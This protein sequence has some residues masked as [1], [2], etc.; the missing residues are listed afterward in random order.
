MASE[1]KQSW[2]PGPWHVEPV[3]NEDDE[4]FYDDDFNGKVFCVCHPQTECD[5]TTVVQWI[6]EGDA[7]LIAAAPE[8]FEVLSD[9]LEMLRKEAPGT[10]LNNHRFDALGIK[11]HNALTKARGA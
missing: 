9:L 11:A 1:Q 6:N 7:R 10:P 5:A 2:T 8:L 3:T 4:Q